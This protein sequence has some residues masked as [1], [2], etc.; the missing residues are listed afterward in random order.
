VFVLGTF[1]LNKGCIMDIEFII[2][3]ED[4][5]WSTEVYSYDLDD[6]PYIDV[7]CNKI[8]FNKVCENRL[9]MVIDEMS[10]SEFHCPRGGPVHVGI[11]HLNEECSY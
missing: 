10:S 5:T 3:W 2:C 11:Y 4:N 8:D 1:V 6:L 7:L 9:A